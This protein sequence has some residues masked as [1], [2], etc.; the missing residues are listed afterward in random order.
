MLESNVYYDLIHA[1]VEYRVFF[2]LLLLFHL[3]AFIKYRTE[4]I[5]G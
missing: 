2:L 4:T 1:S 3:L 5:H